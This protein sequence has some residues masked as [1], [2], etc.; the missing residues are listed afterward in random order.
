M[1]VLRAAHGSKGIRKTR[2]SVLLA[3]PHTLGNKKRGRITTIMVRR[4][5]PC[6]DGKR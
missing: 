4:E 6:N 3:L 2:F 5:N 1:V